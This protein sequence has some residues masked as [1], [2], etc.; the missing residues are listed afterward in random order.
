MTTPTSLPVPGPEPAADEGPGRDIGLEPPPPAPRAPHVPTKPY[1]W[2]GLGIVAALI[3]AGAFYNAN[4]FTCETT[5]DGN[6]WKYRITELT[7]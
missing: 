5:L 1:V 7:L 3:L 4:H 2:I 6:T